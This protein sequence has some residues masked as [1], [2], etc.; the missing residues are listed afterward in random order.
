MSELDNL[1]VEA[2]ESILNNVGTPPAVEGEVPPETAVA[3]AVAEVVAAPNVV[4]RGAQRFAELARQERILHQKAQELKAKEEKLSKYEQYERDLEENPVGFIKKVKGYSFDDITK[5]HL[6]A[7]DREDGKESPNSYNKRVE[8]RIEQLEKQREL[9]KE[10]L[11]KQQQE[12]AYSQHITAVSKYIQSNKDNYEVIMAHPSRATTLYKEILDNAISIAGRELA[13]D[14]VVAV[15][16]RTEELLYEEVKPLVENLTKT[17][18]FNFKTESKIETVTEQAKTKTVPNTL[19]NNLVS[20][21]NTAPIKERATLSKEERDKLDL[22]E[23]KKS[24]G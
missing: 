18:K 8:Q 14:E 6:E 16:N 5:K 3:E 15:I 12:Q 4:D 9:E 21:V 23:I 19:T 1:N 10:S 24:F 13:H 2:I 17:K 22:E 7:L 20:G 11:Y